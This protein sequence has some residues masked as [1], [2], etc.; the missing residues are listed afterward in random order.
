MTPND[1]L[2]L[3][4]VLTEPQRN[5]AQ[6]TFLIT[7]NSVFSSNSSE[8]TILAVAYMKFKNTHISSISFFELILYFEQDLET[9]S[10]LSVQMCDTVAGY[11]W[12]DCI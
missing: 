6:D 4:I 7:K 8:K 2:V 11:L 9:L 3:K 1:H 10:R 12:V 5:T